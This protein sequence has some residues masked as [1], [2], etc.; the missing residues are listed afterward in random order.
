MASPRTPLTPKDS[1]PAT[2]FPRTRGD[3]YLLQL[4]R[5]PAF[6]RKP[7]E[8]RARHIYHFWGSPVSTPKRKRKKS[9]S[10]GLTGTGRV[11]RCSSSSSFFKQWFLVDAPF[12]SF[13]SRSFFPNL[14]SSVGERSVVNP[15]TLIAYGN[16]MGRARFTYAELIV[17]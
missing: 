14:V 15:S 8:K 12:T 1:Q 10:S 6:P 4:P 16:R 7:G 17:R 9:R 2:S 5:T 3:H 11:T 13:S